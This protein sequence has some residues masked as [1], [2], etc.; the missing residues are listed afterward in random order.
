MNTRESLEKARSYLARL[1]ATDRY[2]RVAMRFMYLWVG[3]AFVLALANQ[4]LSVRSYYQDWVSAH[5]SVS[6]RS[7]ARDDVAEQHCRFQRSCPCRTCSPYSGRPGRA[8]ES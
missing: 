6:A 3:V 4:I 1:V 2:E 7:F 5:F 8:C